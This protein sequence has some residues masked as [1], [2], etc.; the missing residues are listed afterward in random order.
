M[1][2]KWTGKQVLKL[3]LSF[4]ALFALVLLTQLPGFLSP[5]YWAVCPIL[6]AFF[7]AGPITCVMDMKRGLGSAAVLPLLWL[8]VYRCVGEMSMPLMWIW[9]IAAIVISEIVYKIMGY[10]TRRSIRVCAPLASLTTFGMLSPLYL[11]KNTFLK[12]AAAEM[13]AAY[14]ADLNKYGTIWMFVLVLVL[15]AGLAVVSERLTEKS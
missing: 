12:R 6:S 11:Q 3:I 5:F 9:V 14:V 7:A 2:Q 10:G 1:L 13:D 4:A 8:I 15:A